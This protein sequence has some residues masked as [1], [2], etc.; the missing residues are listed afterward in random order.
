MAQSTDDRLRVKDVRKFRL[1]KPSHDPFKGNHN[2][3]GV[4]E[5]VKMCVLSIV[6]IPLRLLLFVLCLGLL[7]LYLWLC[8]LGHNLKYDGEDQVPQSLLSY[9]KPAVQ[10]CSRALISFLGCY[11]VPV[12]GKPADAHEV[13]IV[14]MNHISYYEAFFSLALG[15]V[16]I[17]KKDACQ[18]LPFR[19]PATFTQIIQVER[20]SKSSN[21]RSREKISTWLS[22]RNE[23]N[24]V[25]FACY[26]EGTTTTGEGLIRF[27]TGAFTPGLPVQPLVFKMSYTFF[28]PSHTFDA[29]HWYLRLFCQLVNFLEAEYL[30]PYYPNEEEKK[31]PKLF[32]L[33]VREYMCSHSNL[34][35]SEFSNHD[36]MLQYTAEKCGADPSKFGVEWGMFDVNFGLHLQDA[37][38]L[39]KHFAPIAQKHTGALTRTLFK[40]VV[41]HGL[42]DAAPQLFDFFDQDGDGIISFRDF[43]WSACVLRQECDV[44]FDQLTGKED[45]HEHQIEEATELVAE[46]LKHQRTLG[47]L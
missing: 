47:N 1:G 34:H 22:K 8:G 16:H 40:D 5:W 37:R 29:K 11:H 17:G 3:P 12:K 30:P 42:Q 46:N 19:L 38:A 26:P 44:S 33:N 24:F 14:V 20:D 9:T 41:S 13:P 23:K 39:V 32:A 7:N 36:V 27:K 6:L 18:V 4:W 31:N 15:F 25:Q 35:L 21:Q 2:E 45:V 10:F 28:D 43:L